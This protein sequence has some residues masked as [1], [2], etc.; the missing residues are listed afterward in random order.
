[1]CGVDETIRY[2]SSCFGDIFS[3]YWN[4]WW[5]GRYWEIQCKKDDWFDNGVKGKSKWEY[6]V[7]C[8][9]WLFLPITSNSITQGHLDLVEMTL[10]PGR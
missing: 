7:F 4:K 3:S 2:E 1:M 6:C 10:Q 5:N 8:F 9:D